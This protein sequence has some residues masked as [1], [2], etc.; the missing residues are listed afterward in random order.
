M[1]LWLSILSAIALAGYLIVSATLLKAEQAEPMRG[2]FCTSSDSIKAVVLKGKELGGAA[3]GIEAVNLETPNAC[4]YG[5][6]LG[7]RVEVLDIIDTPDGKLDVTRWEIH[8][9]VTP[10]GIVPLDHPAIL[11]TLEESIRREA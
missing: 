8:A 11:F 1:K 5:V 10:L 4:I 6:I 9:V 2:I 3:Q 7:K